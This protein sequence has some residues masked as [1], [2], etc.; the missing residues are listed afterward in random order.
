MSQVKCA[1]RRTEHERA[2]CTGTHHL[3]ELDYE[4][5][6]KAYRKLGEIQAALA[7]VTDRLDALETKERDR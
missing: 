1:S 5:N 3:P 6:V 4:V 7:R 2:S